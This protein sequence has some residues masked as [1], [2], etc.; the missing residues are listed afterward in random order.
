[1]RILLTLGLALLLGAAGCLDGGSGSQPPVTPAP[2]AAAGYVLDCSI[3]GNGWGEPCLALASPNPSPSKTEIDLVV[4]PTDPSNVVV[5]SKDN[6]PAASPCVWAI[7]QVTKDGGRT[8]ATSYVG[9]KVADRQPGDLLYRW[10]CITDPIMAFGPDG[11]LYYNL[12]AYQLTGEPPVPVVSDVLIDPDTAMMAIAISRDGGSTWAEMLP[13]F[14]GDDLTIFPD[15]MR[16]AANPA[17]G[18]AYVLWN[19]ITALAASQPTFSGY[20]DGA[21]IPPTP[22]V[23][24]QSP[25]GLGESGIVA[26]RDGTVYVC[27][28]GGN[29][30]GQGYWTTSTDDGRTFAPPHLA[31]TFRAGEDTDEASFRKPTSVEIDIDQSGGPHDGCLYATWAGDEDGAVGGSDVYVRRSCDGGAAG[32]W[33]EPVLVNA[34]TRENGQFFARATVDG[35]GAVHVVYLTQ[36]YDPGNRLVD[37]EWAVSTDGGATWTARRLTTLSSDGDLGVHQNGGPFFGDYIGIDSVGGHVWMGFPSTA[38][39]VAEIAVAHVAL[40]PAAAA[41]GT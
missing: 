20:R 37:A 26:D 19:T 34:G 7:A 16:M 41:R 4:N 39:G 12:Q 30:G 9:G 1:M 29:S 13:Q 2:L 18:S 5:A 25:T 36:A 33:Q 8:W 24:A 17:T 31:F 3:G 15:Y 28:C 40:A 32:S 10:D 35:H 21:V 14:F 38:T 11:T 27:L 23:T 22:I 6:D